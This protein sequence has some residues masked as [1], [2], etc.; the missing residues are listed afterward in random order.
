[1]Y[2]EVSVKNMLDNY[3]K[4]KTTRDIGP[5]YTVVLWH[6]GSTSLDGGVQVTG[7]RDFQIMKDEDAWAV[8]VVIPIDADGDD[9]IKISERLEPRP[10]S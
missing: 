3:G 1:M 2:H 10:T 4:E 5:T 6:D 7:T 9:G 8:V